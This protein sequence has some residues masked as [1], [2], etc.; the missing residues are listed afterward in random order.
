MHSNEYEEAFGRFLERAEYDEAEGALFSLVR[1]AFQAGWLA[2]G[3]EHQK[4]IDRLTPRVK[5]QAEYNQHRI[6]GADILAEKVK[7]QTDWQ[8]Q[9][10]KNQVGKDHGTNAPASTLI[11]II[12]LF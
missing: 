12:R 9:I 11:Y 3:G 1:A 8:K 6:F 5:N 4:Q 7:N 10:Q 2:A